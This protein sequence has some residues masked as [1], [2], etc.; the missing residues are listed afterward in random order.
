MA[1]VALEISLVHHLLEEETS[2]LPVL[3]TTYSFF[4]LNWLPTHTNSRS[5]LKKVRRL[6]EE[7]S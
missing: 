5:C 3:S 2:L 7:M 1:A 4:P 6:A